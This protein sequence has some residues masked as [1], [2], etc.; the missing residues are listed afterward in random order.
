M[1]EKK[2]KELINDALIK[3]LQAVIKELERPPIV[4]APKPYVVEPPVITI[5]S[6]FTRTKTIRKEYIELFKKYPKRNIFLVKLGKLNPELARTTLER[7]YAEIRQHLGISVNKPKTVQPSKITKYEYEN[8]VKVVE[9]PKYEND[10]VYKPSHAKMLLF[11]DFKK[12]K[13][14]M[15]ERN[16]LKYGFTP[17]ELHWLEMNGMFVIEDE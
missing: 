7:R 14:P 16:L 12:Y 10:D 1:E 9:T 5:P 13:K 2:V 17:R 11:E 6:P 8:K 4:K 15:T 3:S